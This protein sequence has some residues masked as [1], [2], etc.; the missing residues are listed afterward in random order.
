M[1]KCPAIDSNEQYKTHSAKIS[2]VSQ[3]LT[4]VG[5]NLFT[6]NELHYCY[7]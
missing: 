1:N 6:L 5:V 4:N 3:N 7:I 2:S